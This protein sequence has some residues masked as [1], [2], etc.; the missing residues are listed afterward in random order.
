MTQP[1]NKERTPRVPSNEELA[2]KHGLTLTQFELATFLYDSFGLSEM[3]FELMD[4]ISKR[5]PDSK[6]NQ[7]FFETVVEWLKKEIINSTPS[8]ED[9]IRTCTLD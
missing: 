5:N 4:K 7:D 2:E 9:R 1:E 3:P 6:I 8:A